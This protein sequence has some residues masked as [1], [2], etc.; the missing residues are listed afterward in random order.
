MDFLDTWESFQIIIGFRHDLPIS[1]KAV[2]GSVNLLLPEE[3]IKCRFL[4]LET[5]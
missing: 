2:A 4:Y 3:I 1:E 5:V